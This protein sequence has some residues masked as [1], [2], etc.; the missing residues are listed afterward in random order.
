MNVSLTPRLEELVQNQVK[1][2][3]YNNASEVVREALRLFED[4]EA[5][6]LDKLKA[7]VMEGF[8]AIDRGEIA[9]RTPDQ[10]AE[11]VLKRYQNREL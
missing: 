5:G 1:S 4:R 3:R 9:K 10:I 2:G 6:K 8:E 11:D 7:A